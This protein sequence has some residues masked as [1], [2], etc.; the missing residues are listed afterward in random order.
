MTLL[1]SVHI[2][3]FRAFDRL[4]VEGLT[5]VNLIVGKNN[6][7]KTALLNALELY[8]SDAPLTTLMLQLREE[9]FVSAPLLKE[10]GPLSLLDVRPLF[11][12][13][14]A[15]IGDRC[16]VSGDDGRPELRLEIRGF[17]H[18]AD[19]A[20]IRLEPDNPLQDASSPALL[21]FGGDVLKE[22]HQLAPA[23]GLP[24]EL[25]RKR[26]AGQVRQAAQFVPPELLSARRLAE[27]WNEVALTP[28]QDDV[29]KAMQIVEPDLLA[30]TFLGNGAAEA[31]YGSV[32]VRLRGV[33]E[34]VALASMGDGLKR[35][36]G[37]SLKLAVAKGGALLIDEI[38]TGLHYSTMVDMWRL[39]VETARR[40]DI[41]VFATTH[42][43]D[44]I[45]AIRRLRQEQPALVPD[46]SLHRLERGV[47][48]AIALSGDG[49][50]A[51]SELEFE[52]R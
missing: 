9:M 13:F 28:A 1:K 2:E 34:R 36:L 16:R 42:N 44:C 7:G 12:G 46:V 43:Q 41:Q 30:L 52:V 3:R 8:F 19:L 37:L 11:H 10:S 33:G 22:A 45:D 51:A 38:D 4:D 32:V 39:V 18:A 27:F 40:L 35:I 6:A 47:S 14:R 49:I 31:G 24:A 15:S 25:A 50:A 29:I 17:G 26:S 23:G 5:R 48:Q 20:G 21:L